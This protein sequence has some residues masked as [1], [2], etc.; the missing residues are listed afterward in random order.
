MNHQLFV[1]IFK[2]LSCRTPLCIP[3][4][5]FTLKARLPLLKLKHLLNWEST[6]LGE[7]AFKKKNLHMVSLKHMHGQRRASNSFTNRMK[8]FVYAFCDDWT[9]Y[10]GIS[11]AKL[12]SPNSKLVFS[13]LVKK[14]GPVL[15]ILKVFLI[16]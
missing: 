6:W 11:A 14:L 3:A 5:T 12:H 13:Y 15:L 1:V 9:Q 16:T 2:V 7:Y 8:C 10:I 4:L